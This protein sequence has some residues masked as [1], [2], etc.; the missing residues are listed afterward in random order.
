MN[1]SIGG[2]IGVG[3]GTGSGAGG[4]T[5]G[6]ITINAQTGPDISIIGASGI[7]VTTNNNTIYISAGTLSGIKTE[8]Y[9]ASFTSITSGLFTHHLNSMDV[10]VQIRSAN[11]GG[12]KVLQPDAI[13]IENN[14]QVSILYNRPQSGRVV[15]IG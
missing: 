9:A 10:I 2:L 6:I 3:G 1:L 15:I 14:N 5:S 11:T 12:A 7:D 4:S 13:V 8:A